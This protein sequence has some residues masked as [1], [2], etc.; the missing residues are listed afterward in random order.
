MIYIDT[1]ALLKLVHSEP[2]TMPLFTWL[3]RHP[4]DLISSA[5]IWAESR[6]ALLRNDPAALTDLQ[7]VLSFVAQIPVT[8]EILDRAAMLPDPGLRTLDGIHLASAETIPGVRTILAYDRRLA[9]A[10]RSAGL[11]VVNPA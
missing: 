4:E 1:S 10:A 9:L 5:L 7:R 8:E 11:S 3:A 6:R 2:E